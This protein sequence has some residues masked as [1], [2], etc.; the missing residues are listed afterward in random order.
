[1]VQQVKRILEVKKAGHCGTLDPLAEGVLPIV[2]GTATK[3]QEQCMRGDK[4]YRVRMCLGITTDTGDRAGAVIAEKAVPPLSS[5]CLQ[6]LLQ[7]FHGEIQQIPPM[8][9]AIKQN[10]VRLYMLAREGKTVERLPRT[11][12]IHRIEVLRQDARTAEL[13]VSCTKGTYIRTLVE[14][15]GTAIGC[16]ATVDYLCREKAGPFSLVDAVDGSQLGTFDRTRLLEKA[17]RVQD[18]CRMLNFSSPLMGED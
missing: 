12:R 8:Y 3:L 17:I 18:L 16:G 5:A 2:F 1:V 6:S 14:D 11:V 13:R 9:S 7:R 4:T 15:I 10:G